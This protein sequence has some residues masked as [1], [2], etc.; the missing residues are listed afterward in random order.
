MSERRA[1]CAFCR[2]CEQAGLSTI[3]S[4]AHMCQERFAVINGLERPDEHH[5]ATA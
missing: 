1:I 2:V 4:R 5:Q 3:E